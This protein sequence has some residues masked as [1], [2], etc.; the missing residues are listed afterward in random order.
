MANYSQNIFFAP[1]DNLSSGDP[2]KVVKGSEVDGELGLISTAIASK[3]NSTNKGVA[4]GYASLDGSAL[5]PT[6]QIP[7]LNTSKLTSGLL[8]V[9]RGGTGIGT[10]PAGNL[11]LGSGTSAMTPLAPGAAGS[12]VRSSGTTWTSSALAAGDIPNL[13]A[14]KITSGILPVARGGTGLSSY[15]AG[16]YLYASGTGTIAHRT[17]AQ[18]RT[19]INAASAS[20]SIFAGAGLTGGGDLS[21]GD[22]TLTLGVPS[23]L[24]STT[25]NGISVSS[26]T[27]AIGAGI[28]KA[29]VSTGGK[30]TVTTGDPPTTGVSNGD[31]HY[32]V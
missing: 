29:H 2:A 14:D 5:V 11:L 7:N 12:V 20:I 31:I 4:N 24:T 9:A 25:N 15:T 3:E 19:N 8:S 23:T 21:G 16:N 30:T 1:K 26:H 28:M 22:R 17:P 32:K 10:T 6:A 13:G 18:V 27:H